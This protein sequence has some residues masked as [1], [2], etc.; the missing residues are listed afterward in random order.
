MAMKVLNCQ[1]AIQN[2]IAA[3]ERAI[4]IETAHLEDCKIAGIGK[5]QAEFD[6][7]EDNLTEYQ[8]AVEEAKK[9]M[10]S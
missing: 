1:Q 9:V 7:A 5:G 8:M 4:R 10:A 2:L 6:A 3:M